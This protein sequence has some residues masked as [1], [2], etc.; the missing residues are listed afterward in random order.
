MLYY[1]RLEI[2]LDWDLYF[3]KDNNKAKSSEL[4]VKYLEKLLE[5]T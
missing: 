2:E 4:G 1:D 5:Y 3:T